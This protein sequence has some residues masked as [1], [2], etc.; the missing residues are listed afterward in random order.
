MSI[1]K[2][3]STF[4]GIGYIE[5]GGGTVAAFVAAVLMYFALPGRDHFFML[6][7]IT[8][9]V[10]VAGVWS[11]NRVEQEWGHDSNKVV[12]DEVLGMC[13]A[14]LFLPLSLNRLAAAFILFRFFDILKPLFIRRAEK[15][16]GG[17]G[18][19]CDDLLAGVYAN[20]LMQLLV[21]TVH[22]N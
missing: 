2:L 9:A 22:L 20:L 17:W 5:K 21:R 18:V 14:V 4:G 15:L 12:I 13:V 10:F 19:M 8:L 3:V 16:P 11:A 7:F 6:P 1:A